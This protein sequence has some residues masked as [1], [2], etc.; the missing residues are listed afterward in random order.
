MLLIVM[1]HQGWSSSSF[2]T[3]NETRP[4]TITSE[5]SDLQF[6]SHYELELRDQTREERRVERDHSGKFHS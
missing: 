3:S 5:K 1:K 2:Q 4:A 6:S